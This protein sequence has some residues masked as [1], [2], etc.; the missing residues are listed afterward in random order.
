L[1]RQFST[2]YTWGDYGLGTGQKIEA[3][4]FSLFANLWGSKSSH[5]KVTDLEQSMKTSIMMGDNGKPV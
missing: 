2:L 4:S 5:Q 1:K 3:K